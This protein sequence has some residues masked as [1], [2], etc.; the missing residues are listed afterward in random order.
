MFDPY[1]HKVDLYKQGELDPS[2]LNSNKLSVLVDM[3]LQCTTHIPKQTQID[4]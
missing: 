4:Q 3:L 2:L 1:P